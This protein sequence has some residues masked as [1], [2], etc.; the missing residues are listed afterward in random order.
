M[1]GGE[2]EAGRVNCRRALFVPFY[3][4]ERR[5]WASEYAHGLKARRR[6][7]I[8]DKLTNEVPWSRESNT[9]CLKRAA[10]INRAELFALVLPS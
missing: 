8:A 7:R 6:K 10:P 3:T 4:V 9:A 1:R 2:G 5:L